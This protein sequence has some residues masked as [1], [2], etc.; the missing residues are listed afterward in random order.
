MSHL[1]KW[2]QKKLDGLSF[3]AQ[4]RHKSQENVCLAFQCGAVTTTTEPLRSTVLAGLQK[5]SITMEHKQRVLTTDG[6]TLQRKVSVNSIFLHGLVKSSTFDSDSVLDS[7]D[8]LQ[9][10]TNR[11]G[12][13]E[14]DTLSTMY[15]YTS[16]TLLTYQI[17]KRFNPTLTS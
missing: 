9:M 2:V 14:M 17:H 10:I 5:V 8:P 13:V 3:P 12:Q 11:S 7:R 16:K 15:L 6:V 4:L 1:L